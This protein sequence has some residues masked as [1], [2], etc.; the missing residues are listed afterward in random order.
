MGLISFFNE[1]SNGVATGR[2][3]ADESRV[4]PGT[5]NNN[6]I[7]SLYVN[8]L[9]S[10]KCI[11]LLGCST[12]ASIDGYNLMNSMYS[13]G[14]HFIL[15]TSETVYT[16]DSDNFLEGFLDELVNNGGNVYLAIYKGIDNAGETINESGRYPAVCIGDTRQ[17]LN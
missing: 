8:D 13:R 5:T 3:I 7:S 6:A 14:A 10:A 1:T 12:G 15:G 2:I 16:S 9:A 4:F 11:L 17:Y